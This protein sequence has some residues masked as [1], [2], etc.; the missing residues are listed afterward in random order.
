[1]GKG[2]NS[3][4]KSWYWDVQPAKFVAT[5]F[6]T[7]RKFLTCPNPGCKTTGGF[8]KDSNGT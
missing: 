5:H 6:G 4:P 8:I 3:L 7:V 1:M 2:S